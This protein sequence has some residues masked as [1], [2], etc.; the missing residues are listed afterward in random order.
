MPGRARNRLPAATSTCPV[1]TQSTAR[2]ATQPGRHEVKGLRERVE[3]AHR[4]TRRVRRFLVY[5]RAHTRQGMQLQDC[6]LMSLN[7][8]RLITYKKH[9]LDGMHLLSVFSQGKAHDTQVARRPPKLPFFV[10]VMTKKK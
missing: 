4:T 6:V 5:K 7:I 3:R 9:T 2:E 10:R 1:E 8:R